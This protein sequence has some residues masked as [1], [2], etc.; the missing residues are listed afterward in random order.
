M[1]KH[2]LFGVGLTIILINT[3]C[4]TPNINQ[5]YTQSGIQAYQI[6]CG[7]VFGGGDISACY[8]AAG[9]LCGAHG[10]TVS[11][12]GA[13]SLLVSCRPQDVTNNPSSSK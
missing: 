1:L 11:N 9:K 12:I 10:Y 5:T 2:S 4:S 13:S 3:G 6:T 8:S 7:G